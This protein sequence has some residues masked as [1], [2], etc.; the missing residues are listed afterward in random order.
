MVWRLG[1]RLLVLSWGALDMVPAMSDSPLLADRF[2]FSFLRLYYLAQIKFTKSTLFTTN[3]V[4]PKK[5][6]QIH[7]FYK[8]LLPPLDTSK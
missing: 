7:N 8:V 1:N 4:N 3:I 2:L 5:L 6:M